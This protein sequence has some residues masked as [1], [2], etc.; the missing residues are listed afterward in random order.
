MK[1][2]DKLKL[3][4]RK[5]NMRIVLPEGYE[6]RTLKAADIVIEEE[7]AQII[8][9]G[10]PAKISESSEKYGLR[11]I[12]RARVVNPVSH[13]RK[14]DYIK[15]MVE[16]RKGKGVTAEIASDLIEDPLYL[17]AMMIKAGDAD[18]EV[19]GAEH[20]TG[21]VLRPAFQYV[22]TAPGIS[23]VSGAFLM[24]HPNRSFGADGVFIFAD[25]AVHPDPTAQ[26]L[27]EIAVATAHTARTIGGFEPV[28]AMLSFSTKGSARHEMVDKVINATRIAREMAPGLTIDG[29]LQVDAA[30]VEEIGKKKAPGSSIPGKANVLIFPNLESGNIAY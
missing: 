23:I 15:M 6:E 20:S 1:L 9:I 7:I 25:G 3:N 12:S 26:E 24:I 11:N 16:M 29:E 27:A 19:A 30:L 21:A 2:L 18:G 14:D 4:A 5:Y 17:A 10:D 8:L 22:K 28:V 13:D